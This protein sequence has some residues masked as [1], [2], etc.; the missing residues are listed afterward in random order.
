MV[1]VFAAPVVA[2][3]DVPLKDKFSYGMGGAKEVEYD[4]WLSL[5]YYSM[6]LAGYEA[7]GYQSASGDILTLGPEDAVLGAAADDADLT[8][9]ISVQ[10]YLKTGIGGREEPVFYWDDSVLWAEW[11][12]Q[13]EN[14]GLYQIGIDYYMPAG[15]GNPAVRSLSVDGEALFL[16]SSSI[17]F[18]RLWRDEGEPILNSLGD[19]VRP[20]QVEVPGWNELSLNDSTGYY[21]DPFSF[22]FAK[23]SHR[24]RLEYVDQ[25]VAIAAISLVPPEILPSYEEVK[26]E[27][28]RRGYGTA[29]ET[30]IFEA[31]TTTILKSDPT[32]RRE[33][34]TDPASS[35]YS[36]TSRKLNVIGGYRWR[37]GNQAVTWSFTV[38]ED[39]LYEMTL[40][41]NQSWNEGLPSYRQIAIDGEVPFSELKEYKF[42][43]YLHWQSGAIKDE[44]GEPYL[45][46]LAAGE[47]TLT[48]TVKMGQITPVIQSLNEDT[49]LLS[50]MIREITKITGSEP[51][52][53]Y[54]Y[55]FFSTI[56]DLKENMEILMASLQ[57]KY[58]YLMT[59][60][61]GSPA[62]ANNFLTIKD[63]LAD[64]V[65]DPFTI[66]RQMDDLDNAQTSL[67]TWYLSLQSQPLLID[68]YSFCPPDDA[69]QFA[70]SNI[71]QRLWATIQNFFLSFYKDYDNVGSVLSDDTEVKAII[72]VW[73][74]RGTEWAELIKEMADE[75]FTPETGIMVNINVIPAAQLN[76]GSVNALMLS[77]TSGKA[78]DVGIGV[79]S[80]SPVEFAIRD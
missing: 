77:I 73:V 60:S 55:K 64:M 38:P 25:D 39:G 29:S 49:I 67:S 72:N 56:P 19:E 53:N 75:D 65:E 16:E 54:D 12:F 17:S 13:V 52:P 27:Y 71:F 26:Q 34:N 80:N 76:A 6:V 40:R 9:A 3:G 4:T 2:A 18:P 50:N 78:P 1:L 30:V 45:F 10:D 37:R 79:D 21:A 8:A 14:P 62:M 7:K 31:E 23:G 74:A 41:F 69:H 70:K 46:Y 42:P 11:V 43:Y 57:V 5:P 66:A 24:I 63:Q 20:G 35:P 33:S 58:D 59:I 32:V 61:T 68:K 15:S 47:H 28:I 36:A 51:D 48:M 22:Y 44:S